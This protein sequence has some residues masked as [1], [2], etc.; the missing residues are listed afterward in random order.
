MEQQLDVLRR[1]RNA[2]YTPIAS[3]NGNVGY[4]NNSE[5]RSAVGSAFRNPMAYRGTSSRLRL[6][7]PDTFKGKTL[8]EARDF[9]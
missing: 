1:A 3:A 7:E 9:I 5:A 2:G 6:K 8:K 4:K